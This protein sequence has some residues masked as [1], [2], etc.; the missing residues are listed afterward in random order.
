MRVRTLLYIESASGVC[1]AVEIWDVFVPRLSQ[2]H[3]CDAI[4]V[5]K[6]DVQMPVCI[7][8]SA[9]ETNIFLER[10]ENEF[11]LVD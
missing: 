1:I 4:F 9:I 3:I 5:S 8:G 6:R 11:P 10:L 7:Q 2:L